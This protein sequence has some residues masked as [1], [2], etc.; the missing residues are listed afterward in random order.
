MSNAEFNIIRIRG[1]KFEN[2]TNT[3]TDKKIYFYR[4]AVDLTYRL[5]SVK[6]KSN[7]IYGESASN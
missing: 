5:D 3:T 2:V 1:Y 4:E 6:N 7:L